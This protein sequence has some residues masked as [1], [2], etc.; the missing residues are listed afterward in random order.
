M[1]T[2]EGRSPRARLPHPLPA[3]YTRH[4]SQCGVQVLMAQMTLRRHLDESGL[5]SMLIINEQLSTRSLTRFED[6]R[7]MPLGVSAN[8]AEHSAH[9]LAFAAYN[10]RVFLP[11]ARLSAEA[12]TV[13]F[14]SS[15]LASPGELV[16]YAQLQRRAQMVQ[17]FV[18]GYLHIPSHGDR[19]LEIVSNPAGRDE[20]WR[21]R[22][23]N[24][25]APPPPRVLWYTLSASW[26]SW[27][28][29]NKRYAWYTCCI[30]L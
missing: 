30:G 15:L 7:R 10:P 27:I 14:D 3:C 20:R 4:L 25:G 19:P 23:W 6:S 21:K 1:L 29:G 2:A 22:V 12:E 28:A 9:V 24:K 26:C 5:R 13:V 18:F 16:S 17:C 11:A 8:F